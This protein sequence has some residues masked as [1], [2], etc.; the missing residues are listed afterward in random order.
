[1]PVVSMY[2]TDKEYA[3]LATIAL[4]G[5]TAVTTLKRIAQRTVEETTKMAMK[6]A[7]RG[8]A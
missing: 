5:E 1:M 7:K 8:K 2:L 6:A 4:P 3:A